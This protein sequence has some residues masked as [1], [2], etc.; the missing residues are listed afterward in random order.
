M[1]RLTTSTQ[2]HSI[3]SVQS[4]SQQKFK[5]SK[6]SK[7]ALSL[8][9]TSIIAFTSAVQAQDLDIT[10]TNLTQGIHYTPLIISAHDA[11][12]SMYHVGEMASDAL[13][14]MAE[15]G[16]VD[17]LD[18]QLADSNANNVNT[19]D[20]GLLAPGMSVTTSLMTDSGNMYL[21]A[22]AM[23]LPTNDGFLGLDSWKIPT[24]PGT[25]TIEVNGYDAGT[26]A[27]DE[28]INGNGMPGLAGIPAAPGGNGGT[29]ASGVTTSEDNSYIH[30][31]RGNLGD[32]NDTGGKSDLNS[33]IHRWLNPVALITVTVKQE[34]K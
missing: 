22:V 31:H 33:S 9:L 19:K 34:R 16:N 3:N 5:T 27:N 29:Q 18:T 32:D 1:K 2:Q 13:T 30:V 6:F 8:G 23:L 24:E 26:E 12:T 25:Y 14:A 21:S 11:N 17:L 20:Y 28:I 15:G 10:V 7:A 4:E